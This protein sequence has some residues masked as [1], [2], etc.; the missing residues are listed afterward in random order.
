L[1]GAAVLGLLE[2]H[3]CVQIAQGATGEPWIGDQRI[4]EQVGAVGREA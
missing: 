1:C 4:K 2:A 3:A